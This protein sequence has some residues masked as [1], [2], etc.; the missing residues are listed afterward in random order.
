MSISMGGL[1]G[2][3][4]FP[5]PEPLPCDSEALDFFMQAQ[6]DAN[7]SRAVQA[8]DIP[9]QQVSLPERQKGHFPLQLRGKAGN[10]AGVPAQD[11]GFSSPDIQ[12]GAAVAH[13]VSL[14]ESHGNVRSFTWPAFRA[15]ASQFARQPFFRN[16]ALGP[17]AQPSGDWVNG[18][19]RDAQNRGDPSLLPR[20]KAVH[21]A[22]TPFQGSRIPVPS[23]QLGAGLAQFADQDATSRGFSSAYQQNEHAHDASVPIQSSDSPSS[24][25]RGHAGTAQ[26]AVRIAQSRGFSSFWQRRR[27]A[28]DASL[29]NQGRDLS[30][31]LAQQGGPPEG[32]RRD[33][34]RRGLP[35]F[36][37]QREAAN[38]ASLLT[39]SSGVPFPPVPR[40][41][42]QGNAVGHDAQSGGFSLLLQQPEAADDANL[43]HQGQPCP[44]GP[45]RCWPG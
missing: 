28:N 2:Q 30:T 12:L 4:H 41:A 8:I 21:V 25:V 40:V 38:G 29:P 23:V 35:C 15:G 5:A 16:R 13:Q 1:N 33:T 32:V 27:G 42:G 31:P 22:E 19:N 9:A 3:M 37:L 6:T 45:T 34:Q 44:I 36:P 7:P 39:H 24:L 20:V 26:D 43:L 10:G 17:Q 11:S 14:P 18:P